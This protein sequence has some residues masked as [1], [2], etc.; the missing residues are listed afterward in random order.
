[1]AKTAMIRARTEAKTKERAEKVIRALGL[2]P[3]AA[4]TMFYHQI[5]RQGGLPFQP[6]AETMAALHDTETG[7][8]LMHANSMDEMFAELD[9]D[10]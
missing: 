4:I 3:T 10:E 7:E 2:T 6:N 1:M 9:K 8:N 5:I